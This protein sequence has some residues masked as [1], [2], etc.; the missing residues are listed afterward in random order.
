[1]HN[2][3]LATSSTKDWIAIVGMSCRFPEA[4]SLN[5]YW[6]V[7][8]T[9]RNT[10]STISSE[11]RR[12][13]NINYQFNFNPLKGKIDS[14]DASFFG[15]TFYVTKRSELYRRARVQVG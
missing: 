3:L 6:D 12:L 4:N 10:S 15:T 1:M 11:R 14:F 7:L 9:G 13:S 8:A 5:E 2:Q